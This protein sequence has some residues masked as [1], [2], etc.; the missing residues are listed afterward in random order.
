LN[1]YHSPRMPYAI[2]LLPFLFTLEITK[3]ETEF[4]TLCYKDT[5]QHRVFLQRRNGDFT[6]GRHL[7]LAAHGYS[8]KVLEREVGGKKYEAD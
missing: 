1:K 8:V 2:L 5:V 3:C 6:I 4:H 7:F